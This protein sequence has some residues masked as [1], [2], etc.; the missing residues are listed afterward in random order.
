MASRRRVLGFTAV[1]ATGGAGCLSAGQRAGPAPSADIVGHPE[2]VLPDR[3]P[4]AAPSLPD[5]DEPPVVTARIKNDGAA[6]E[7]HVSFAPLKTTDGGAY[8]GTTTRVRRIE[9]AADE[10]RVVEFEDV[11]VEEYDRYRV[12][13]MPTTVTVGVEN[14]GDPGAV[15]V[16]ILDRETGHVHDSFDLALESGERQEV[17]RGGAYVQLGP[18]SLEATATA[19]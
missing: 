19:K 1:L 18:D 7:I 17:T 13:V 8:T 10:S 2:P 11:P 15:A 4:Y 6:G 3:D 12:A 9:L 14:S 16:E 5:D